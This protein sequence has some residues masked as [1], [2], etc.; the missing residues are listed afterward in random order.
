MTDSNLYYCIDLWFS[1]QTQAR[2]GYSHIRNWDVSAVTYMR[3]L[4]GED[5]NEDAATFNEDLSRWN[6]GNVKDMYR[7]F[8]F[9]ADFNQDIGDWD[10]KNVTTMDG[11]FYGAESFNQDISAWNV[12]KVT[13]SAAFAYD[14]LLDPS[15]NPFN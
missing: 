5:R 13:A 8:H 3:E 15:Y 7:M 2:A 11:M 14:T 1:N 9:A 4:F 6:V 10:T 12:S